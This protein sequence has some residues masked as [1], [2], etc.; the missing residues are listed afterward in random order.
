MNSNSSYFLTELM[1][2]QVINKTIHD[3]NVRA[4]TSI[5]VKKHSEWRACLANAVSN[6]CL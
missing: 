6:Q 1:N 4:S 2:V 3:C 5:R